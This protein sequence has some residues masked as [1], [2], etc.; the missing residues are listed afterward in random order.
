V[1]LAAIFCCSL[2]AS[3]PADNTIAAATLFVESLVAEDAAADG[4]VAHGSCRA[5]HPFARSAPQRP[6]R[7]IAA[8]ADVLLATMRLNI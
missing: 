6:P 7:A 8:H 2:A 3:S 4:A 5:R 1:L